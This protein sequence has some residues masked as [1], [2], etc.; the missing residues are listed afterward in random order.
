MRVLSAERYVWASS[1]PV[2]A[3]LMEHTTLPYMYALAQ[4]RGGH[5][6]LPDVMRG[7][8]VGGCVLSWCGR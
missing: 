8:L 5:A 4:R 6:T 1:T 3:S 2:N 7:R